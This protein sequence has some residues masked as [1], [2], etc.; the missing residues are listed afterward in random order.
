M[1]AANVD[2]FRVLQQQGQGQ[3]QGQVEKAVTA[4]AAA[5]ADAAANRQI[6]QKHSPIY[7]NCAVVPFRMRPIA[8][9]RWVYLY[10][11]YYVECQFCV[12]VC[13]IAVSSE[14]LPPRSLSPHHQQAGRKETE[15][16]SA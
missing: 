5:A 7:G 11:I 12:G 15:K 10:F 13:V 14:A 9:S 4:A 16:R 3:R 8:S 6:F 2:S 1:T